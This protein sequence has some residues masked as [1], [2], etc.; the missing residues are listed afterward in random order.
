MDR[1]DQGRPCKNL[2]TGAA[3]GLS[4]ACAELIERKWFSGDNS[5]Q[6]ATRTATKQPLN[7]LVAVKVREK[8]AERLWWLFWWLLVYNFPAF[9]CGALQRWLAHYLV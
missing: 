9:S 2:E 6:N 4:D 8:S 1:S 7:A 3:K 5:H